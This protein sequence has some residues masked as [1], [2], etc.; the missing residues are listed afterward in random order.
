MRTVLELGPLPEII[1]PPMG[2]T[3]RTADPYDAVAISELVTAASE[4]YI[5]PDYSST[6]ASVLLESLSPDAIAQRVREGFR[7]RVA[8]DC[9]RIVGV[10]ALK[11]NAHL[12]HLFVAETHHRRGIARRLWEFVRDEAISLG[13]PGRFTLNASRYA[14]PIYERLGFVKDGGIAVSNDVTCQPMLW[15]RLAAASGGEDRLI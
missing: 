5:T 12:Y 11:E 13:N 3:I 2:E 4:K 6:G 8:V 15:Q 1:Q 10:V 14:I 9:G 7:Y